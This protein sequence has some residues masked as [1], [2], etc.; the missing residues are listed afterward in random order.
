[1]DAGALHRRTSYAEGELRDATRHPCSPA[2]L[3]VT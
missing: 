1:M 3:H 2:K